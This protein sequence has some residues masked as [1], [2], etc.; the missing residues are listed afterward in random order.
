MVIP[1]KVLTKDKTIIWVDTF[2]K[3]KITDPKFFFFKTI[4]EMDRDLMKL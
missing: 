3:W 4:I 1:G 2:A